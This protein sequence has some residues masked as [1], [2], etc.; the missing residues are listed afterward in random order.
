M[1]QPG[2]GTMPFPVAPSDQYSHGRDDI[3]HIRQMTSPVICRSTVI[4]HRHA[5]QRR[6][7]VA[8]NTH[9]RGGSR[10]FNLHDDDVEIRLGTLDDAPTGLTPMQEGWTIRRE[11]WL[12]PL[13]GI[14]HADRDPPG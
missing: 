5:Q 14:P 11:H 12:T 8:P 3:L 10:L 7:D 4:V 6:D 1:C 9:G 13:P 2:T